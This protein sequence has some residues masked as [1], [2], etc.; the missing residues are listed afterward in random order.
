MTESKL[1][2]EELVAVYVKIRSAIQEKEEQH[3]AEIESLKEQME[4][5]SA[6]MLE[7]CQE[8]NI[9]SIRTP[10]GTLSRRVSSRY[11]TNDWDSLYSFIQENDA[12]F[13]L[14]KRIH[15]GNMQQFL[16]EYPDRFPPGLQ[17]DRKYVVQVRK[18]SSK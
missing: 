7:I 4:L 11:W 13:L 9:D 6:Q 15:N 14:E 5:V 1:T 2:V 10:A 17:N 12:P 16:E 18:P 3:K 8:Q